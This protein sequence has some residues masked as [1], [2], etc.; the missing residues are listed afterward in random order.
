MKQQFKTA[1]LEE[2]IGSSAEANYAEV[3]KGDA[4]HTLAD[5]E[6][7]KKLVGYGPSVWYC[8]CIGKICI[9]FSRQADYAVLV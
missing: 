3:Q 7:V 1:E 5:V 4:K 2:I 8:G 6:L 9:M